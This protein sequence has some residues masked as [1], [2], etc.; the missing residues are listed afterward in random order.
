MDIAICDTLKINYGFAKKSDNRN[1]QKIHYKE[2]KTP[3]A[4]TQATNHS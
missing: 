1:S 3:S 2:K 4:G